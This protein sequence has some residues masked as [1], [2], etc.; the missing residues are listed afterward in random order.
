MIQIRPKSI[1]YSH[2]FWSILGH[3]EDAI[4]FLYFAKK[5]LENILEEIRTRFSAI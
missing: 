5:T 2:L 1:E 3:F 4:F